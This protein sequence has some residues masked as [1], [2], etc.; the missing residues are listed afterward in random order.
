MLVVAVMTSNGV[1]G[2]DRNVD[3]KLKREGTNGLKGEGVMI[4][5]GGELN[6]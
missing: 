5:V 1:G 2:F 4:D 6:V 3:N